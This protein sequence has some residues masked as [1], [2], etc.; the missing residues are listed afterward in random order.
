MRVNVA[1]RRFESYNVR[2]RPIR[3]TLGVEG[4]RQPQMERSVW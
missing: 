3:I 1:K 2:T 4:F